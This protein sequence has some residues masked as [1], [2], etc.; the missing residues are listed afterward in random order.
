M[1]LMK[2]PCA[3]ARWAD[4]RRVHAWFALLGVLVFLAGCQ[5][6]SR[7]ENQQPTSPTSLLSTQGTATRKTLTPSPTAS[8]ADLDASQ[9]PEPILSAEPSSSPVAIP[10]GPWFV[11]CRDEVNEYKT[12]FIAFHVDSGT[13]ITTPLGDWSRCFDVY[14]SPKGN[15]LAYLASPQRSVGTNIRILSLPS[16]DLESD[17]HVHDERT[18]AIEASWS[19]DGRYLAYSIYGSDPLVSSVSLTPPQA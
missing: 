6:V 11:F 14:S 8:Q 4:S 2:L 10:S 3:S 13:T 19:P 7:R 1:V 12:E 16:L 18:S 15:R 9:S 17:L 5:T